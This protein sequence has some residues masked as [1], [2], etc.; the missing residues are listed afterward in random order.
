MLCIEE[1]SIRAKAAAAQMRTL[2]GERRTKA[3]NL[4][5]EK[6]AASKEALFKAN[7]E[8]LAAA[9]DLTDAFRKRLQVTEKVFT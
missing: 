8:D 2:S 7:A 6:L 9:P 5:A 4:M 1:I 3:L